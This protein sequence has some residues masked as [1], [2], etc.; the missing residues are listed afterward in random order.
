MEDGGQVL[1]FKTTS[2]SINSILGDND[3]KRRHRH[4]YCRDSSNSSS[5]SNSNSKSQPFIRDNTNAEDEWDKD[6]DKVCTDR[7]A[8]VMLENRTF[9]SF[10]VSV[11]L[12]ARLS[13]RM[14]V[15][16]HQ[17]CLF[18]PSS[19]LCLCLP[20]TVFV[21]VLLSIC[22]SLPSPSLYLCQSL[23][24]CLSVFVCLSP[25]RSVFLFSPSSGLCLCLPL[26]VFVSLFLSVCPSLPSPCLYLCHSVSACLLVCVCLSV[27]LSP[28]R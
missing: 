14:S 27:C 10:S 18:S 19:S 9:L 12:V 7:A 24:V 15:Y 11:C 8:A 6:W 3:N 23:P 13:V 28:N 16:D 5:G 1:R 20:L 2:F 26:T 25:T 4:I 21:S 22:P 17:V